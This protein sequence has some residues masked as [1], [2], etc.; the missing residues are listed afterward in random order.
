MSNERDPRLQALFVGADETLEDSEFTQQVIQRMHRHKVQWL[1]AI[2]VAAIALL[3]IATQFLLPLQSIVLVLT[4][5]L[6]I[7]L[8]DLGNSPAS[9]ILAPI[10]NLATLLII[11]G[12]GMK[13]SWEKIRQFSY[14]S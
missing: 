2:A 14:T 5:A 3:A 11:L 9:W 13:M 6:N 1:F 4:Q 10:N 7:E 12:K 8:I